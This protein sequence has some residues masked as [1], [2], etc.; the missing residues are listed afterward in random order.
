MNSVKG[1]AGGI[2]AIAEDVDRDADKKPRVGATEQTRIQVADR[3][4][5]RAGGVSTLTICISLAI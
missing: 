2:D 4:N 3:P 5:E 1:N